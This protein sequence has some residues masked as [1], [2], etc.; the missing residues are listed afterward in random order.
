VLAAVIGFPLSRLEELMKREYAKGIV[1]NLAYAQTMYELTKAQ[2]PVPRVLPMGESERLSV[3]GNDAIAM[4]AAAAGLDC[5]FSYPMTPTTGLLHFFAFNQD[6][7]KLVAMQ[8]ENE[9]AVANMAIGASVAGARSMVGTSG[10]GFCLMEEAFS[11]AGMIEAPVLFILGQRPGPSTGG[12]TYTE[13][14]DLFFSLNPGQGEFP[15][16]VA[17]PGSVQEAFTLAGSMLDLVWRFQTP[18]ILLTEKHLTESSMSVDLDPDA[19]PWVTSLLKPTAGRYERYQDTPDGVSPLRF[20]P[21]TEVIKWNS[22]E[23]KP[24]GL[25]TEDPGEFV[26]MHDKRRRKM[27][28]LESF[29]RDQKTVNTFGASDRLVFT[30]GSTTMS[31]R[32]AVEYG[33]LPVQIV[34][35]MYL[36]P[37][38][39]WDLEQYRGRPA[40]TVEQNSTGQL[41]MMVREKAGIAIAR[42]VLKYDGRPFEPT[43]LSRQIQEA[44]SL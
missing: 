37:F 22:Y 28:S 4:G 29:L 2:V 38:P 9:I 14:A 6:L 42:S 12:P 1:D 7:L 26:A 31:V 13:Q 21:S 23:H 10:G 17:S 34:Q 11:F 30:F 20:P 27:Q 25:T 8:P 36:E 39:S 5:Y 33:D 24:S 19:L 32:E 3:A 43:Q 41:A 35:P 15:R 18:G 16:I 40:I 44:F